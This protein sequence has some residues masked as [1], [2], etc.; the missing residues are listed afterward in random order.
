M[1]NR[2]HFINE[3]TKLQDELNAEINKMSVEDLW[4][5]HKAIN[6]IK[7]A[8]NMKKYQRRGLLLTP[9]GQKA[10]NG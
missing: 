3:Q 1:N 9:A 10:A 7:Y 2:R 8:T 5:V 4:K 6:D